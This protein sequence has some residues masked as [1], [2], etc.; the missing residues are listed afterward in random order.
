MLYFY[1]VNFANKIYLITCVRFTSVHQLMS[2]SNK[3]RGNNSMM[4]MRYTSRVVGPQYTK[5]TVGPA[6]PMRQFNFNFI[7]VLHCCL[8]R[9]PKNPVKRKKKLKKKKPKAKQQSQEPFQPT[10]TRHNFSPVLYTCQPQIQNK[11][12]S[13]SKSQNQT[14]CLI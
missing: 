10:N 5:T 7:N 6:L 8:R 4:I 9:L 13:P 2:K 14:D 11:M 1:Y 3:S 12:W